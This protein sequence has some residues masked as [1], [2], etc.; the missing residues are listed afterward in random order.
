MKKICRYCKLTLNPASAAENAAL[1]EEAAQA[2]LDREAAWAEMARARAELDE[3]HGKLGAFA[4][5]C[6]VERAKKS[7]AE[8]AALEARVERMEAVVEAA[9]KSRSGG[10]YTPMFAA[11]DAL[12]QE[13]P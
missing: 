10:P 1:K 8:N 6:W 5:G 11:L 3:A 2:R 12:S 9:A 7:E 4:D 13:E